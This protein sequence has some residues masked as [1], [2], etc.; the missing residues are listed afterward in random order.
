MESIFIT[1]DGHWG[2][3]AYDFY[4][5]EFA[6]E[7]A[8]YKYF[9]VYSPK[10]NVKIYYISGDL[11][12]DLKPGEFEVRF[13]WNHRFKLLKKDGRYFIPDT[14]PLCEVTVYLN[15]VLDPDATIFRI[16]D[17]ARR[18]CTEQ[19]KRMFWLTPTEYVI[20][21]IQKVVAYI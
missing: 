10:K 6:C 19:Y 13:C 4:T 2:L 20:C 3:F 17:P 11:Q 16:D 14:Q 8:M 5:D 21:G 15:P 18:Y 9:R 12:F 1:V 7:P